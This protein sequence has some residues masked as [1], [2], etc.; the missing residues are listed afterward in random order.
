[1]ALR[2]VKRAL[3]ASSPPLV[4]L[5]HQGPHLPLDSLQHQGPHLPLD[6]LLHQDQRLHLGRHQRQQHLLPLGNLHNQVKL[7]PLGSLHNQARLL[8]LA[9]LQSG[10]GQTSQPGAAAN[11]FA[12]AAQAGQAQQ[13]S[14]PF[15]STQTQT[16]PAPANP[17]GGAS[18][19]QTSAF[20]QPGVLAK[21]SPFGAAAQ[22][23][24][25][26]A[27]KPN[28]FAAAAQK[29]TPAPAFGT[30]GQPANPFAQATPQQAPVQATLGGQSAAPPGTTD[31]YKEGRPEDYEGEQGQRLQQIYQRVAQSGVFDPNEDIPLTPPKSEWVVAV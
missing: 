31:P 18:A 27:P 28:P 12:Q 11:P 5:Q 29:T 7:Q 22:G 30:P 25:T 4:S 23:T 6:S 24:T 20:G 14:N 17:F 3:W 21:P 8:H 16:A 9:N 26:I 15:G 10:F 2:W 13:A 1:V 19:P